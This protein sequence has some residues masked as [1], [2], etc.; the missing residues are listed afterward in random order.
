VKIQEGEPI[1]SF[2]LKNPNGGPYKMAGESGKVIFFSHGEKL[3][4]VLDK[5]TGKPPRVEVQNA[6]GKILTANDLEL[7][8]VKN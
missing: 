8:T 5:R 6:K 3:L 2:L 7:V 1:P 4:Q